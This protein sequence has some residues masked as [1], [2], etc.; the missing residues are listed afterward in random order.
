MKKNLLW[1]AAAIMTCGLAFTSCA[2]KD[3]PA[4]PAPVDPEA[5]WNKETSVI[6]FEDGNA[7]FTATSRM[8]VEVQDNEEKESKVLALINAKNTQNGYGFAYYNF[9][10][11]VNNPT[12]ITIKFDYFNTSGGRG[13]IT[14]G[15][16]EVRGNNGVGAGFGKNSYGA[17]GAIFRVGSDKNNFFVNDQVLGGLADW[18]SKWL[19]VEVTVYTIDRQVE[20]K[21]TDLAGEEI[22]AQSGTTE[23]EGEE[24]VFT[25]GKIDYWKADADQCNQIDVFGFINNNVSYIDNLSITNAQDPEIKYA[26]DVKIMF[27]DHEGNELKESKVVSARVGTFIKLSDP[28]MAPFYN[29][30]KSK[31]YIFAFDNAQN[32]PVVEKGTVV[33]AVFREAEKFSVAINSFVTGTTTRITDIVREE[34]VLFEGETYT[35]YVKTG[36]KYD[37]K[38]YFTD[39]AEYNNARVVINSSDEYRDVQGKKYIFGTKYYSAVDSV[40]YFSEVEDMELTGE[41]ATWVGWTNMDAATPDVN[42]N[43]FNRFSQGKG[44]RLTEGSYFASKEALAAGTY[45]ITIYGRSSGSEAQAPALYIINAAGELVKLDVEVPTLG[46]AVTGAIIVENVVIPEGA[47][48]VLKNDGLASTLDLDTISMTK[49]N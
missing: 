13:Q 9:A 43:L 6:D 36:Y 4:G 28:D 45:K 7:V 20:W 41:V 32:N 46:A 11:K 1:M 21:I 2:E 47:K 19:T 48:I 10:D 3:L 17:K 5:N 35:L 24:A 31:K 39:L 22:L 25:P 44:P 42:T 8:S 18:C 38:Y 34:D 23:G 33:K 26:D 12:N 37:G 15:D 40:A 49:T 29:A 27:V 30:D 14:I 16:A